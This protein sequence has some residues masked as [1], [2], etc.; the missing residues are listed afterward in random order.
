[1]P[2]FWRASTSSRHSPLTGAGTL[3]GALS[4]G[5]DQTLPEA[6]EELERRMIADALDRHG[7][8]VSR[9]ARELGITRRGLQLKL[10]R[11]RMRANA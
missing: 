5:E 9:A 1:M 7:G 8:N 6:V 4:A 10:G 3:A 11:Y 2:F